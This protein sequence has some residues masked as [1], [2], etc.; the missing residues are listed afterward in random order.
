MILSSLGPQTGRKAG[1]KK[2]ALFLRAYYESSA[3]H[4]QRFD[5]S[6][7]TSQLLYEM[8]HRLHFKDEETE[9]QK[10]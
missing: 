9:P 4:A 10:A 6:Y 1:G 3:V 7:S 2:T 5:I 8:G